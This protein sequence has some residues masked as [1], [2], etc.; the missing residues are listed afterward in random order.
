VIAFLEATPLMAMGVPAIG[1]LVIL[2]L[3]RWPNLREAATLAT[4][5]ALLYVV[6]GIASDQLA[7][8]A[9]G[10]NFGELFSLGTMLPGLRLEFRV[11]ALGVIYALVA[12]S[13]WILNSI[14]SIGYMRAHHEQN[15]TRFYMCFSLAIASV[16]GIAFASNMFT[17]FVFYE[18]LTISTFPLVAHAGTPHAVR[19]ARTYLGVLVTTSVC[20]LLLGVALTWYMTGNLDFS[21]AG[22]FGQALDSGNLSPVFFAVLYGLYVYGIGKAAVMPTH[23][24]LPAAMVAPTPVSALL[25]AV[26]VVKAGVFSVLKVTVYL[27]GTER[28]MAVGASDFFVYA[29]C[30]TILAGSG[31]AM[32]QD[33]LK[34]RLAYS[35]ISQLSYIVLGAALLTP[36]AIE[37]AGL[38]LVMHAWGKITLFFCAGAIYVAAH[39]TEVSQL[40]G[41]GRKMPFTFAAF[42]LASISIIGLPPMGGSWGKWYL[43]IGS[44]EAEKQW[45]LWVL[46]A[47]S[48]LNIA[49]LLPVVTTAF[50]LKPDEAPAPE[51]HDPHHADEHHASHDGIQEAPLLCVIPLC[52]TAIGSLLLFFYPDPFL[53]LCRMIGS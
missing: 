19:S 8:G 52:L 41:L 12:A 14:Y 47:S 13:L 2:A 38:H 4:A 45:V 53:D 20:F 46:V 16:M 48:L 33:N 1:A 23:R 11:E 10:G 18:A 39:K 15:Q 6:L 42:C 17:L 36:H 31:V 27:F 34:R 21:P 49:Y 29:A 30:F 40:K 22:V 24:W 35:T 5:G 25:H 51:V 32:F 26:A 28:L 37:G 44:L 3:G 50:F 43:M 9:A 7:R